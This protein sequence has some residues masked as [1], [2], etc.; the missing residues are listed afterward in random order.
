VPFSSAQLAVSLSNQVLRL[1]DFTLL[2]PEGDADLEYTLHT[3]TRQF[4]WQLQ[5]PPPQKPR[6]AFR[7]A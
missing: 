3:Q 7:S 2:R 4:R 6:A 5:K 1:L